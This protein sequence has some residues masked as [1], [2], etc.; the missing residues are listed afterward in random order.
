MTIEY[1]LDNRKYELCKKYVMPVYEGDKQGVTFDETLRVISVNEDAADDFLDASDY[2]IIH[3]GMV[4]QDY[5]SPLGCELQFLYDEIYYQ[6]KEQTK[7]T[8][9]D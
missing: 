9:I 6:T 2:A 1:R 3:Y 7:E 8:G 4:N 5:L